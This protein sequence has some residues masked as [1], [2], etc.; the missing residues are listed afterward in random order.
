MKRVNW[1]CL[2]LRGQP[3]DKLERMYAVRLSCLCVALAVTMAA[4]SKTPTAPSASPE[5]VVVGSI[6]QGVA[7][8]PPRLTIA[9]ARAVGVTRFIAF[10]DSITFGVQSSFDTRFLFA[11]ANGGYAER[12]QTG[13]NVYH[14]PQQFVVF[15]EGVPGEWATDPR[16]LPRLRE[17]IINRQAQAVLLL[18]GIND[19]S[20][21]VG[22]T[23]TVA[24]LGQLVGAATSL[25]VPVVIAT[26]FQTYES[27]R[28]DG[29]V[30]TNAAGEVPAFNAPI[31]QLAVGR[32]NV[33]LVD[34]EPVMRS[35]AYVGNDGLH[36]TDAGYEVMA[37]TVL[38]A[39]ESAFPVRGSF[40]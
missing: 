29:V 33:H 12:L 9:P 23:R 39:I 5:P 26:M 31:R 11:A 16:T 17:A 34:L 38:A 8:T 21:G 20:S 3:F 35:R 2:S 30:R 22:V 36:P 4:C 19:L 25:G 37:S 13:L 18:E 7:P 32:L 24:G 15:N 1:R 40:Q 14:T 10:G 6:F 27:T 28:P